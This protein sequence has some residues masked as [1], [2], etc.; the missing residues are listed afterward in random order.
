[1]TS[2]TARRMGGAKSMYT[3]SR[4]RKHLKPWN[5]PAFKTDALK[6]YTEVCAA[7]AAGDRTALKQ[8]CGGLTRFLLCHASP[9]LLP[10]R[11]AALGR[12][13]ITSSWQTC[14]LNHSCFTLPQP[15][16]GQYLLDG[17]LGQ[18]LL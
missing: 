1:L 18:S 9:D 15:G 10:R 5:L 11:S 8:V 12:A 14:R 4:C 17:T 3:I 16:H 13:P 2:E 7:Q 6:L